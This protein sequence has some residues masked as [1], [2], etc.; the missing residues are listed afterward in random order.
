MKD[1]ETEPL[2]CYLKLYIFFVIFTHILSWEML[3]GGFPALRMTNEYPLICWPAAWPR[4]NIA[5]SLIKPRSEI[6]GWT[7]RKD[8]FSSKQS[9]CLSSAVATVARDLEAQRRPLIY[10]TFHSTLIEVIWTTFSTASFPSLPPTEPPKFAHTELRWVQYDR[11][12][13]S[14]NILTSADQHWRNISSCWA[15]KDYRSGIIPYPSLDFSH[16]TSG[17]DQKFAGHFLRSTK[18]Q[19]RFSISVVVKY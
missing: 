10:P 2:G 18:S 13:I 17:R 1:C 4:S 3:V 11:H 12:C 14:I 7:T 6:K 19:Q 5:H 16:T 8:S 9:P 15:G